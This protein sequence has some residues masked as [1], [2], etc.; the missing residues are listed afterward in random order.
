MSDVST[1]I[2]D[3]RAQ[4]GAAAYPP[5]RPTWK[6]NLAGWFFSAPWTLIFLVF[7]LGPIVIS[8]ILS[9]TD[10]GLS[11]LSNP[12]SLHFVGFQN[13]SKIF[14]DQVFLIAALNT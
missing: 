7:L 2:M 13:Y 4:K 1:T 9:F 11:N 14:H 10:F 3:V 6:H 8:L 12:F 5:P